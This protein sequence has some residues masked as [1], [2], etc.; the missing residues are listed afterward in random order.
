MNDS[1]P[2]G[3]ILQLFRLFPYPLRIRNARFECSSPPGSTANK[4]GFWDGLA[5][6]YGARLWLEAHIIGKL[7]K[8]AQKEEKRS[9][10]AQIIEPM[11][12][13]KDDNGRCIKR[14][15]KR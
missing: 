6:L 9:D 12:S 14:S 13:A 7:Q 8:R 10:W 2:K 11:R 1:Y 3:L 5:P 15:W 4:K